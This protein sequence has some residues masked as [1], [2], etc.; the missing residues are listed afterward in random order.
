MPYSDELMASLPD[1]CQAG[2]DIWRTVSPLICFAIVEWHQPDRVVRQ[3]GFRQAVPGVSRSLSA[4]H[5][6]DLRS[7]G[8]GNWAVKH[9]VHIGYWD[10]RRQHIF[11][12][13]EPDHESF[14]ADMDPYTIWYHDHTRLF[15]G[16]MGATFHTLVC[17][18]YSIA[19]SYFVKCVNLNDDTCQYCSVSRCS[20]SR[21]SVNPRTPISTRWHVDAC[22]SLT[23]ST[24]I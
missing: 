19:F 15:V 10:A 11:D 12:D 16:R 14:H 7:R 21:L 1:Y 2:R 20:T 4:P 23:S 6:D 8:G 5:F 18:F 24:D 22:R 9:A 17:I 3:F 13:G